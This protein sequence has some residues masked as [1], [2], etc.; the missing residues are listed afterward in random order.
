MG[1]R[2]GKPA[3]RDNTRDMSRQQAA[4]AAGDTKDTRDKRDKR[5]VKTAG[6]PGGTKDARDTRDKRDTRDTRDKSNA[7]DNTRDMNKVLRKKPNSRLLLL[8]LCVYTHRFGAGC[9]TAT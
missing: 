3:P 4:G 8:L 7:R 5:G 2:P 6:A 9:L 1:D